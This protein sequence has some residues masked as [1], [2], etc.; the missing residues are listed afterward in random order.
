MTQGT[1]DLV[2]PQ[3]EDS[4]STTRAVKT[5]LTAAGELSPLPKI[6]QE[7]RKIVPCTPPAHV[8]HSQ[9]LVP[10]T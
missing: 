4:A 9:V 3:H 5:G 8:N 10:S 2:S 7:D 1:R 6:T